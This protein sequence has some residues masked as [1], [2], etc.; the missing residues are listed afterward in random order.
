MQ[1]CEQNGPFGP[2]GVVRAFPQW[3][4]TPDERFVDLA[5]LF[6]DSEDIGI[7]RSR[8]RSTKK[9]PHHGDLLLSKAELSYSGGVLSNQLQVLQGAALLEIP[10]VVGIPQL[11]E[12]GA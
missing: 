7:F 2:S 12:Q 10:L 8:S 5:L 1:W 9:S 11:Y 3:R 4:Q 6:L